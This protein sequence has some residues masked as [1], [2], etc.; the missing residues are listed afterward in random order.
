M[1]Q[2]AY[3]IYRI[4]WLSTNFIWQNGWVGSNNVWHSLW[5]LAVDELWLQSSF[6]SQVVITMGTSTKNVH[7]LVK[8]AVQGTLHV[9][10]IRRTRTLGG[11]DQKFLKFAG[12]L[13]G[14]HSYN[15]LTVKTTLFT[16]TP[17]RMLQLLK[18]YKLIYSYKNSSIVTTTLPPLSRNC[19]CREFVTI[20]EL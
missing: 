12:V 1:W 8:R 5:I 19:N 2:N 17:H 11:V 15:Y 3:F 16:V 6:D 10:D 18:S 4:H 14:C 20:G 13:Y 7:F 9:I